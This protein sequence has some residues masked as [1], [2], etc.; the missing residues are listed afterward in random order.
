MASRASRPPPYPA[1]PDASSL[2]SSIVASLLAKMPKLDAGDLSKKL[3]KI[4]EG[5]GISLSLSLYLLLLVIEILSQVCS[6]L[7]KKGRC[8]FSAMKLRY[9]LDVSTPPWIY[10]AASM[11]GFFLAQY[12]CV[13]FYSARFALPLLVVGHRVH[14]D[15]LE[16]VPRLSGRM[17]LSPNRYYFDGGRQAYPIDCSA[18]WVN[19]P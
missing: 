16:Q 2:H 19:P 10:T 12:P 18:A 11:Y 3:Q 9:S 1:R 5:L 8:T 15:G 7:S 17:S 13:L 6:A 4:G 14:E